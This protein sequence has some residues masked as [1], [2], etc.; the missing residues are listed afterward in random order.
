M[1]DIIKKVD[2]DLAK[3]DAKVPLKDQWMLTVLVM[4]YVM[5]FLD[6]QVLY[7]LLEPIKEEF[8]LSDG[9]LGLLSGV[10]FGLFYSTLGIP[11]ARLADLT[12]R[13]N[14]L[15]SCLAIWSGMTVLCGTASNFVQLLVYRVLVGVGEAGASPSSHSLIADTFPEKKRAT[16]L[17]IY[18]LGIPVGSLVALAVGGVLAQ[19]F[20]WR[21]TFIIVGAPGLILALIAYFTIKEP[22]RDIPSLGPKGLIKEMFKLDGYVSSFSYLSKRPAFIHTAIAG[23]LFSFTG[24]GAAAFLPSMLSRVYDI[25]IDQRG[26]ILAYFSAIGA[27]GTFLAGR[28]TDR[29]VQVLDDKSWFGKVPAY[30]HLAILPF[31]V[32]AYMSSSIYVFCVL[33]MVVAF[34][35]GMYLGP[36]FAVIQHLVGTKRRAVASAIL[37]FFMNII[38]LGLGPTIVGYLSDFYETLGYGAHSVAYALMTVG[39]LVNL[40]GSIHYIVGASHM[41]EN[42]A[43]RE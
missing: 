9:Q 1:A 42:I 15:A 34:L 11:L 13:K 10:A 6:R 25:P 30:T 39:V 40:W 19:E 43:N 8:E 21:A 24:Y 23:G 28:Y 37:L 17:S 35:G 26:Y 29:I 20:G 36:T 2:T 5:N 16:A 7:I 27:V 3:V 32:A 41:E 38:G 12:S 31:I 33:W 18:S 22:K 14:L 4:V